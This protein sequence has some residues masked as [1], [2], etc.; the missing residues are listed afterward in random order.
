[1]KEKLIDILVYGLGMDM[2]ESSKIAHDKGEQEL[3]GWVECLVNLM[4]EYAVAATTLNSV[5]RH[6]MLDPHKMYVVRKYL[7]DWLKEMK[8]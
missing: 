7:K 8:A 2:L 1:M 3:I 5:V 6:N 4:T